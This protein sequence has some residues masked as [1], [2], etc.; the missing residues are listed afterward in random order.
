MPTKLE[1]LEF[2]T[3]SAELKL[4]IDEQPG[5]LEG[6]AAVFDNA[7]RDGDV[8]VKGAFAKTLET[9]KSCGFL[10]DEHDWHTELGTNLDEKEDDFG[11]WIAAQF[12]STPDAQTARAKIAEKRARNREQQMSIG[13]K[14]LN[15]E[16]TKGVRRI[17]DIDLYEVS[18]VAV[19]ANPLTRVTSVKA[20]H[21]DLDAELEARRAQ[22][23]RLAIARLRRA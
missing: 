21:R 13:F 19:G 3:S 22:L 20:I 10:C 6:Y 4:A 9:F 16:R 18:V 5:V 7:D 17:L 2:K 23:R 15:S 1:A 8:I 14:T 12:C 11:L